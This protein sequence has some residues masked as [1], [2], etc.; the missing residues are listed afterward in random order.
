MEKRWNFAVPA[1]M[2]RKAAESEP[3]DE[4]ELADGIARGRV[5]VVGNKL[6]SGI[7]NP[8][9]VGEGTREE[10]AAEFALGMLL[11]RGQDAEGNS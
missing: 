2:I 11:D 6:R 9:A 4:K 1:E 8:T 7:V 5:V 10:Q 3:L